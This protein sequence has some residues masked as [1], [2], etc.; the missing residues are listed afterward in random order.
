MKR[1]GFGVVASRRYLGNVGAG[2]TDTPY[3]FAAPALFVLSC[4]KVL[5]G[6][7]RMAG[8]ILLGVI[9]WLE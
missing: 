9:E 2:P 4:R 1:F 3:I 7:T 5:A 8:G 6:S